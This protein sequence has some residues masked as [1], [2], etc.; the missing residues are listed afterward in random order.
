MIK[1][2]C[3][4]VYNANI[5]LCNSRTDLL[6]LIKMFHEEYLDEWK[7]DSNGV[8]GYTIPYFPIIMYSKRGEGNVSHEAVHVITCILHDRGVD[9]K[10]PNEESLAYP[11]GWLVEKWYNKDGWITWKE[12]ESVYKKALG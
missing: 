5:I 4:D 8:E 7:E 11:V 10:W 9:Y 3:L 12:F 2:L 6:K 1:A